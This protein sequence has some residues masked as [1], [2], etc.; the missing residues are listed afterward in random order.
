[1]ERGCSFSKHFLLQLQLSLRSHLFQSCQCGISRS[2]TLMIA[3]VMRAA[4][5]SL[6]SA[7]PEVWALKG[8]EGA[9]SYVKSK[10]KWIGPN[11]S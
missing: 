9:Y 10:S 2:A 4:A 8:Y 11:M 6:S 1:V 7:P 5:L 3:L